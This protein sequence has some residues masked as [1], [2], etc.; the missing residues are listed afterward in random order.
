LGGAIGVVALLLIGCAV[1]TNILILGNLR[2]NAL[3]NA[4]ADLARHTLLLAE[5]TD[6]SFES[7]DL[8]LSRV[9]DYLGGKG[10]NDVESYHRIVADHDTH[11][12]LREKITGL[13][14]VD[15]VILIDSAGR[16]L[17]FSR[18]WPI[19]P[20]NVADRDYYRA[21]KDDPSLESFVGQPVQT[22]G[23]GKWVIYLARRLD[24]PNGQFLGVVLG[25][26]SLRYFEN[27]F[28]A[29]SLGEGSS[30]SL[31][32]DDGALIAGFPFSNRG[33]TP[34]MAPVQ[35]TLAAGG[36]IRERDSATG[37][38]M[39]RSARAL[40]NYGLTI[41]ASR[42]EQAVLDGW[43]RTADL[44]MIMAAAFACVVLV[45]AFVIARWWRARETAAIAARDANTAKSSFLAMMSH[46]IRTPM[47]GVL[48]LAGSLLDD[49]L[50]P[51]QR[52]VV[53]AIRD[54]GNDLLRILND[55]L[56]FSKLDASKMTFEPV[57][58]SPAT[59]ANGVVSL[60]GARA[61]A[62]GLRLSTATGPWMPPG[63]MGDAGRI[64][65][66]LINLVSNAIK[67]T[68]S[69]EVSIRAECLAHTET[70][71]DMEWTVT[72]TGI[73]IAP[74]RVGMLFGDFMQA[75]P[76]IARRF[77]GTGLGLAISKRLIEQMGG[78]ISVK[79]SPGLGTTFRVR[80]TLPIVA[81]P[82]EEI[83]SAP[84]P[85][86]AWSTVRESLGR[87]PRVLF[88]EDNATNQ[89][90]ARQMLKDLDIHL[91]M[92][93]NGA[94]A[95]EAACRFSYDVICM[96]MQMP[97]MDGLA[98]TRM[99]RSRGGSLAAV[100]IIAL[101]ANALPQDMKLCFEAGM[102]QFVTKPVSRDLL[103]KALLT[104]LATVIA[105]A[106]AACIA[107]GPLADSP[108]DAGQREQA[109]LLSVFATDV[110][111]RL[112]RLRSSGLDVTD[113]V[114]EVHSIRGAAGSVDA[115]LLARCAGEL[116]ARLKAGETLRDADLAAL[117]QMFTA[118]LEALGSRS[119]RELAGETMADT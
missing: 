108:K 5:Q 99:I 50:S 106:P 19:P 83:R 3:Q 67:F 102:N 42:T 34:T 51:P 119:Q 36:I 11:N 39:I 60:L 75:D 44:M 32:R 92:V 109:E 7:L 22:R 55:I 53:R 84:G 90:V 117:E 52:A 58:F 62:S 63:L 46:E 15:A 107:T 12:F 97:E 112:A 31:T 72:D 20:V 18:Y 115:G 48:G 114:R 57:A 59:L 47:N 41:M 86:I 64:R 95:V 71:A 33:G 73:G 113:I 85:T 26:I 82:P 88:A 14:E 61:T 87:N 24:D 118:S 110:R 16:L 8:V 17:N 28:G 4:E 25:S 13:A 37:E 49:D 29:T 103:V 89:F 10:I 74:D 111:T 93:A 69:G 91:D 96:D 1:G 68:A 66:V 43:R 27:F 80:L 9:G 116:E 77:G 101:T 98:A 21:L 100:P 78:G 30:V 104:A 56:D 70:T 81:A 79:S 35:R 2:E 45:A 6:R 105:P 54:S 94:E 23:D 40:P 65:Q 38:K 76:S